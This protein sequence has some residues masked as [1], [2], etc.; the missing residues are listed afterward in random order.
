MATEAI[1]MRATRAGGDRQELH[2]RI[3][4]HAVAAAER[5][6]QGEANDLAERILNDPGFRL[7]PDEV[8]E[9]LDPARHIG[10]APQQVDEF[11]AEVVEPILARLGTGAESPELRA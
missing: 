5:L 2:E 4:R 10:R 7:S 8:R 6:K 11:L 9:T 1:L 3:R